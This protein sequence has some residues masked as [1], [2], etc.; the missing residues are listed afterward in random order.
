MTRTFPDWAYLSDSSGAHWYHLTKGT[1]TPV[2]G[3]NGDRPPLRAVYA[4][5]SRDLISHPQWISSKEPSIITQVVAAESEKL[6]VKISDGPG[7]ISDWTPVKH[8]GTKT[9]VQSVSVPWEFQ[10]PSQKGT[11]F[12]DFIPQ[13]A[14]FQPPPNAIVLWREDEDWVVGYS[15]EGHW[16]HVQPMGT[17]TAPE[18]VGEIQ[19]T[20]MELNAKGVV[21]GL[22]EVVV[23]GEEEDDL[24]KA[25][26][27]LPQLP[28][29]FRPF[30]PANL[31]KA[32]SWNFEPHEVSRE[33]SKAVQRR[34]TVALVFFGLALLVCLAAGA[35]FHLWTLQRT[36]ERL[37]ERIAENREVADTVASAMDQWRSLSPAIEPERSAVE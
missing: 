2:D 36:N 23:W 7:R 21:S 5:P 25:L 32:S 35:L 26:Q 29:A 4:I 34:K 24:R 15:R 27:V 20:L 33:R 9:L 28:V 1:R 37:S 6:G 11:Q 30:P 12:T 22:S 16:A 19:L 17:L 14:L 18:M 13:Y 8:N 3:A 31:E 10:L